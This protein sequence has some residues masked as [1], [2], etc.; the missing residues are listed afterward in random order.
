MAHGKDKRFETHAKLMKYIAT[1]A[2]SEEV[3]RLFTIITVC[4]PSE[5]GPDDPVVISHASNAI[6]PFLSVLI[7]VAI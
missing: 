7:T 2:V 4:T 5:R 6:V 1:I 3:E